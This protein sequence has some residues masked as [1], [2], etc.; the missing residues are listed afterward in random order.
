M[1]ARVVLFVV[2]CV[3]CGWQ[4]MAVAQESATKKPAVGAAARKTQDGDVPPDSKKPASDDRLT[5]PKSLRDGEMAIA[6]RYARFERMLSQMADV[7]GRQD[8]ERADL[9]RRAISRGRED[10]V[11]ENIETTI[12][13]LEK[14]ELGTASEKQSEVIESL[15]VLLKLLQSEDRRSSVERERERLNGLLKDVRSVLAEQKSARATTRNSDAPSNAAP[16]QQRAL[17]QTDKLLEEI[18]E[19]DREQNKEG[20]DEKSEGDSSEKSSDDGDMKGETSKDG[21]SKSDGESKKS[22]GDSKGSGKSA[23]NKSTDKEGKDREGKSKSSDKESKSESEKDSDS[24]KDGSSKDGKNSS[25]K[26]AQGKES[27]GKDSDSKDADGKKSSGKDSKGTPSDEKKSGGKKSSG[28]AGQKSSGKQKDQEQKQTPGREQLERAREEME[29]AL[30][31]LKQQ[32][33]EKALENEDAALDE[34]QEAAEQLEEMLKQLREEEK[35][36]LLASLEARFQRMLAVET[37]IKEGTDVLAATPQK[38]WL[39]QYYAQCRDLAQQQSSIAAEC[40][41]TVNLLKE[42]GTSVSILMAVEDIESDMNSVS[43]WLQ[44]SKVGELTQ[45]AQTDIIESLKQLIET[46]QKEMQE[47]K[48]QQQQQQQ[49]QQQGQ[50]EPLVELMAEIRMLRNLQL[51]VNRRTKQVDGLMK[52]AAAED[53]P[54]L[55]KQVQDLAVRQRRL[56]ESAKELAKQAE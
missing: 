32:E 46:T 22:E 42:D 45:S 12:K 52:S 28:K 10:Q 44:E 53:V 56:I 14:G 17:N 39:D 48:E 29:K 51:Q 23:E 34:L 5:D 38:D 21:D 8:P 33:R 16:G 25:G 20:D 40:S 9:L 49:Q 6:G 2:C 54:A 30:E 26:D 15:E 37:Q 19:H 24:P 55:Q 41:Q 36:M 35:E 50:T 13:L 47:M 1:M 11:K 43:G 3:V 4:W 7:L 18:K 27:K 31:Q